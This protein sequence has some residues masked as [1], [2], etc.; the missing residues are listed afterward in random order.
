M[1]T[2]R[3]FTVGGVQPLYSHPQELYR[4]LLLTGS[5]SLGITGLPIDME[6]E[7]HGRVQY[8]G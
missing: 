1:A 2:V 8:V 3:I 4:C 5:F 6:P 7:R